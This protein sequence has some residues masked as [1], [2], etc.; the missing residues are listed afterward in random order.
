MWFGC[1]VDVRKKILLWNK[2]G[3]FPFFNLDWLPLD[4]NLIFFVYNV[5]TG[6]IRFIKSYLWCLLNISWFSHLEYFIRHCCRQLF[7]AFRHCCWSCFHRRIHSQNFNQ[8]KSHRHDCWKSSLVKAWQQTKSSSVVCEEISD[9][10]Q[11]TSYY[12]SCFLIPMI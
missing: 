5:L 7:K 6:M 11:A 3:F 12:Q 2:R 8:T 9:A 10:N 1:K 4:F